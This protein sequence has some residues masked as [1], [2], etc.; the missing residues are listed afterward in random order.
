[1]YKNVNPLITACC[2]D[3][4]E[5]GKSLIIDGSSAMIVSGSETLME[6]SL[7]DI[8]IPV[9]EYGL[10]EFSLPGG[11]T[12]SANAGL[13]TNANGSL[14]GIVL[15]VTYPRLDENATLLT[16]SDKYIHFETGNNV[17]PVG[18]IMVLSGTDQAGWFMYGSPAG[19]TITNPHPNF[20]V[21]VKLM[22]TSM[23]ASV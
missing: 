9:T 8:F 18:K 3:C 1:M 10:Q 22:Y 23:T 15:V 12:Y 7:K 14:N 16:E 20:S 13:V 6:I 2:T 19:F 11:A 4:G 17:M 21:T 5:G